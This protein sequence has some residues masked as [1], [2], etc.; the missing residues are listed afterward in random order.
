MFLQ[1][2]RE[3]PMTH[4]IQEGE[5]ST[6]RAQKQAQEL[7][8]FD[9]SA[10]A[11]LFPSRNRQVRLQWRYKRFD[12]AA[13]AIRFAIEKMTEPS[14]LGAYLV[15]DEARFGADQIRDLYD[16]AAYPLTRAISRS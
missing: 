9:F 10:P 2:N 4:E 14:L 15:V 3:I 1:F 5:R 8:G 12:T 16:D 13:E 11:E 7:L 6:V